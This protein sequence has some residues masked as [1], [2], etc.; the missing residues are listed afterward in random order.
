MNCKA[1]KLRFKVGDSVFV[2]IGEFV[3]GKIV[4]EWDEGNPYRVEVDNEQKTNV[5]VPV[6]TDDYCRGS[7]KP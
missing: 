6:D 4:A 3:K 7:A 2:N 5:W 1:E